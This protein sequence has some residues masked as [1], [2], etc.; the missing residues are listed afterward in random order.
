MLI[1][2]IKYKIMKKVS[3]AIV[4]LLLLGWFYFFYETTSQKEAQLKFSTYSPSEHSA[5]VICTLSEEDLIERKEKLKSEIFSKTIKIDEVKYGYI[6]HF[7]D[8]PNLLTMLTEF[9]I[10]EQSCCKFFQ[11]DLSIKPSNK[12][13]AVKIS[14]PVLAKMML[15]ELVD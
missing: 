10:S 15:K 12:G 14:G 5:E 11:Y 6:F 3:I 4:V 13:I 9:I 7:N 1:F 8:D 2:V